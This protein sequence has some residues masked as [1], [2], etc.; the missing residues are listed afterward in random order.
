MGAWQSWQRQPPPAKRFA[1][2]RMVI[3]TRLMI[4]GSASLSVPKKIVEKSIPIKANSEIEPAS[5]SRLLKR[6][7]FARLWFLNRC[8]RGIH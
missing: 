6:S 3:H 1:I 4:S 5:T 7:F 8:M 2:A